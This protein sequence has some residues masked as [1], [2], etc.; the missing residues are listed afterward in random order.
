MVFLLFKQ[1]LFS[2]LLV[3]KLGGTPSPDKC[4]KVWS[5]EGG[6]PQFQCLP[7]SV[8]SD[9]TWHFPSFINY[10]LGCIKAITRRVCPGI[11]KEGSSGLLFPESLGHPFWGKTVSQCHIQFNFLIF[12]FS[13][14]PPCPSWDCGSSTCYWPYITCLTGPCSSSPSHMM[15]RYSLS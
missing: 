11:L 4:A 12:L 7:L 2:S 1:L 13:D 3:R 15:S 8:S 5:G 6:N 10:T 14:V 9:N